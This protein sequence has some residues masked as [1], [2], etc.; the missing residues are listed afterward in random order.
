M[1]GVRRF[2]M[3]LFLEILAAFFAC[4]YLVRMLFYLWEK[5]LFREKLKRAERELE[6]V[7]KRSPY[8]YEKGLVVLRTLKRGK[9][10]SP[11]DIASFY[12]EAAACGCGFSFCESIAEASISLDS[13]EL[14]R[15]PLYAF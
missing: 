15:K 11:D 8:L 13:I 5:R 3:V 2:Q 7:K 4:E 14:F 1:N 9:A 6:L 10:L 12:A